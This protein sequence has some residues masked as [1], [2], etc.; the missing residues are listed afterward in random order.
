MITATLA[1]VDGVKVVV[2]DS[3]DLITPYVLREQQDWFEDEI[4]FLR[5]ILRAGQQAIDI[6]ANYGVYTLSMAGVVGPNGKVWAFE[7][8]STTSKFLA[9]SVAANGFSQVVLEQSALSSR[10]GSARLSL[11]DQSELNELIRGEDRGV[12]GSEEVPLVTLDDCLL[13]HQWK[14]IA[15][16]K[17]D[18]EGEEANILRGG[19]RLF[20]ELSP[21][22]LYEVKAANELHLDLI[23][24]F[25]DLGYRS[26]RLVP[27]LSL[28]APF[29]A[30]STPDTY[31]V[32]LFCCKPDRAALLASEGYLVDSPVDT[33]AAT[34][35]PERSQWRQSLAAFPYARQ[36]LSMWE[37]T[38]RREDAGEVEAALA[39]FAHSQD[40]TQGAAERL[41]ALEASFTGLSRICEKNSDC[42]RL[43]S[44]ARVA[45]AF[46]VRKTAVDSLEKLGKY[47]VMQKTVEAD[48]PFLTPS[49]RFDE[50][51][52]DAQI[53]NWVLA[54]VLE[55]LERLST[56][57]SFYAGISAKPRLEYI[58]Q[59]GFASEEMKRRLALVNQRFRVT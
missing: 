3:L 21:L 16:L 34:S 31:L 17:M 32:N 46:G 6:G 8:A 37:T 20:A 9:Q 47:I 58:N 36:M 53:G 57:S 14:D 11:N 40:V 12:A 2:P 50:L 25:A 23:Q 26:Y 27:G 4:K 38:A 22:V 54:A 45:A 33:P 19:K 35:L 43:A 28:L 1:M 15:V 13:R 39:F 24:A 48:E 44:L 30:G 51:P 41:A 59:L 56:F 52:A 55:E 42:L 29:S 10:R 49:A 5:K 18:A 7:P